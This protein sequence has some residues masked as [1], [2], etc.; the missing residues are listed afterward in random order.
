MN[1]KEV[2]KA[3]KIA[4][5]IFG[6]DPNRIMGKSKK[7]IYYQARRFAVAHARKIDPVT[8]TYEELGK[9]LKRNHSS[10]SIGYNKLQF[11][12]TYDLDLQKKYNQFLIKLQDEI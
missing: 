7:Q 5:N 6:A 9:Y 4:C 12:L 2:D 1:T 3:L 8:H 11:E 10:L